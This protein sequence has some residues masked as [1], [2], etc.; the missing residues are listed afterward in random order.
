MKVTAPPSIAITNTTSGSEETTRE[1]TLIFL[2]SSFI[3]PS[4]NK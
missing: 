3:F 1:L 4:K 2:I